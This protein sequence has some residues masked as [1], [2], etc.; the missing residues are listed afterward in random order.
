MGLIYKPNALY[1]EPNRKSVDV[2]DGVRLS[3][4]FKGYKMQSATGQLY[5][6]TNIGEW[7]PLGSS[8]SFAS[9]SETPYYNNQTIVYEASSGSVYNNVVQ[10]SGSTLGWGVRIWGEKALGTVESDNKMTTD[11]KGFETGNQVYATVNAG[12]S[13]DQPYYYTFIDTYDSKLTLGTPNTGIDIEG[14]DLTNTFTVTEGV[15]IN[16]TTGDKIQENIAS[17]SY[18]VYKVNEGASDPVG[19]YI[20]MYDTE[21]HALA[22][23][24]D[25]VITGSTIADTTY[26]VNPTTKT[27]NLFYVGVLGGNK[28]QLYTSKEAALQGVNSAI[29]PLSGSN[30]YIQPFEDSQ[31]VPWT[32]LVVNSLVFD[33]E[34]F[35]GDQT[36]SL[37]FDS[38]TIYRYAN[39]SDILYTGQKLIAID[40]DEED[41]YYVRVWDGTHL[42]LYSSREAAFNNDPSFVV[43]LSGSPSVIY[44]AEILEPRKEFTINWKNPLDTPMI[45]QWSVS[46]YNVTVDSN[47][48]VVSRVLVE[49]SDIQYTG[50]VSYIFNHLLLSCLSNLSNIYDDELGR[51]EIVFNLIDNTGY[52]YE[53]SFVFDVG[54]G[55]VATNYSPITRIN[56]CESSVTVDWRNALSLVGE[57]TG[58]VSMVQDYIYPDNVGANIAANSSLTFETHIPSGTMPTFLFKPA[59][60]NFNG[61]IVTMDGETQTAVLSYDNS[62]H[63]FTLSITMKNWNYA[64]VT[65]KVD[66]EVTTLSSSKVY[67][68]GYAEGKVYIREY[69]D[70]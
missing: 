64:V 34:T 27:T 65:A 25:G 31:I 5:V 37:T 11:K 60:N 9:A 7:S 16:L 39:Y 48:K 32:P 15:Y 4:I 69:G 56:N 43:L 62:T 6:N 44:V 67:L 20:R 57:P 29:V 33:L 52:E 8:F 35:Y 22:G 14:T 21:E 47:D 59:S 42:S 63:E 17:T 30:I 70:V 3:F 28:I 55:A 10:N 45:T 54:Y 61:N 24:E 49:Q 66:T 2:T 38:G 58:T 46:L 36:I 19:Y 50:D 51:Y 1:M 23:G 41:V 68:I 40:N 13:V 26:Y 53:G 18:Y 12:G